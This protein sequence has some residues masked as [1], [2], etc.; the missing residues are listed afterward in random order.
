MNFLPLH[1][2]KTCV[3]NFDEVGQHIDIVFVPLRKRLIA[4]E[5]Q[6]LR[7][8]NDDAFMA[9]RAALDRMEDLAGIFR[10]DDGFRLDYDQ[11][12]LERLSDEY[13]DIPMVAGR[14][15]RR[16]QMRAEDRYVSPTNHY[17]R[18]CDDDGNAIPVTSAREQL[19]M[20]ARAAR[21]V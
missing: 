10:G 20:R 9:L 2:G 17:E 5:E 15:L 6:Y 11:N 4:L 19:E 8:Y 13:R 14:L 16:A 1:N 7:Q 21:P 12:L 3:D 18:D